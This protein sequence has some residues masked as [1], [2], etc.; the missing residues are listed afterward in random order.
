MAYTDS[1]FQLGMDLT[2]SSTAQ[3]EDHGLA[4]QLAHEDRKDYFL[5]REGVRYAGT[6]LL[7]DL[8]GGQGD[9]IV[10]RPVQSPRVVH[11]GQPSLVPHDAD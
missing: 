6:H 1:L 11:P 9:I 7:I 5:E 2:R 8:F 10:R 3:E 4:A